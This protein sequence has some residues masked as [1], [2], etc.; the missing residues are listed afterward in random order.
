MLYNKIR[1]KHGVLK[2]IIDASHINPHNSIVHEK[3]MGQCASSC[4][5]KHFNILSR[6]T[7]S[8]TDSHAVMFKDTHKKR[9]REIERE[10]QRQKERSRETR[11]VYL[12]VSGSSTAH[13]DNVK[14]QKTNNWERCKS[15]DN[16]Y[17]DTDRIHMLS[18]SL[19]DDDFT[20]HFQSSHT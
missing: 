11:I 2:D 3:G 17:T 15:S 19:Q 5:Y 7:D 16:Q 13:E 8:Y 9:E 18:T 1:I 20:F 12:F 6:D 10:S 14:T 4:S